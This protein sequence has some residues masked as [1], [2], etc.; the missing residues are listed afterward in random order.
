MCRLATG[1]CAPRAYT[2]SQADWLLEVLQSSE[3]ASGT[4]FAAAWAQSEQ[5]RATAAAEA[6]A[7]AAPLRPVSLP[8]DGERVEYTTSCWRQFGVLLRRAVHTTVRDP[9]H[10]QARTAAGVA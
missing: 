10:L 1:R 4:D 7:A 8:P 3:A 9:S 5:R 2:H 6:D